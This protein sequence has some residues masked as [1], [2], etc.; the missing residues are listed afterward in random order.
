MA[1]S[2]MPCGVA[3]TVESNTNL[4]ALI[5]LV[6]LRSLMPL[7]DLEVLAG[8]VDQLVQ[9][10][11]EQYNTVYTVTQDLWTTL[12]NWIYN[13]T[14]HSTPFLTDIHQFLINKIIL[15]SIKNRTLHNR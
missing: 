4:T 14:R 12:S 1:D 7:V 15:W 8:P 3:L 5:V 11:L 13:N 6:D 10:D 9:S 2:V